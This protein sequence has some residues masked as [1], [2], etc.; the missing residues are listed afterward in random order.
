MKTKSINKI[1]EMK[2]SAILLM[3]N[4]QNQTT[5]EPNIKLPTLIIVLP[6]SMAS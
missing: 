5:R 3:K 1:A 2:I 6:D 4:L